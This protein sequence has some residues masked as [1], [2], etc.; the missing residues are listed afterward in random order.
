MSNGPDPQPSTNAER[1]IAWTAEDVMPRSRAKA[2]IAG[3]AMAA[4]VG[5]IKQ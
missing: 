3:T 1:V 4:A 2:G 5:A